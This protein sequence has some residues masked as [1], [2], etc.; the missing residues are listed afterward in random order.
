VVLGTIKG[1][2]HDIGKNMVKALLKGNGFEVIDIGIDNDPEKFL[3]AVKKHSPDVVGYSGLLTTTLAGIPDQ[4]EALKK[5]GLRD[6]VL[7]IVGGAPV[8][9]EFAERN[10]VDLYGKDANEAVKVIEKA[11][12]A[13]KRGERG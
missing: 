3:D 4:M 2:L 10:G 8:S 9:R 7:T 11:L 5:S 6:K 1:D 12:A 13:R